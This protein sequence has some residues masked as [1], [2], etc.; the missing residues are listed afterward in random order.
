M[1]L[2]G[3]RDEQLSR[4]KLTLFV[5]LSS[6]CKRKKKKKKKKKN[7]RLVCRQCNQTRGSDDGGAAL[8]ASVGSEDAPAKRDQ[9]KC[10]SDGCACF[11]V[12][13]VPAFFFFDE[14]LFLCLGS[15]LNFLERGSCRRCGLARPAQPMVVA[16]AAPAPPTASEWTCKCQ[17]LNFATRLSCRQ[18]SRRF[19]SVAA[20]F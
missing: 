9:W 10:P 20:W 14:F 2:C 15:A 6:F 17:T 1:A 16:T 8:R 3:L 11:L 18:V 12:V 19:K 4:R 5:W 13:V 7:Q